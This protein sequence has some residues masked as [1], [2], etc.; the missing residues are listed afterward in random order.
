MEKIGLKR[1]VNVDFAHPKLP[2]DYPLSQHIV[3]RLSED[4]YLHQAQE[5]R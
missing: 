3:Y 4:E 5:T 2:V 1:D